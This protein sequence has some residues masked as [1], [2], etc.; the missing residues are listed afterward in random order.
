MSLLSK[1]L[2]GLLP[3]TTPAVTLGGVQILRE[4]E[5]LHFL[6]AGSTSGV[7]RSRVGPV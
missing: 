4:L 7:M 1:V 2:G 3:A 6:L 5:T